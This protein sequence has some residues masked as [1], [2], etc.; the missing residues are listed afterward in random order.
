MLCP[1][2]V[3]WKPRMLWEFRNDCKTECSSVC[4]NTD[5]S[6]DSCFWFSSFLLHSTS[7]HSVPHSTS[8]ILWTASCYILTLVAFFIS[9]IVAFVG[10]EAAVR[11]L[12]GLQSTAELFQPR[13]LFS[14]Y[15]TFPKVCHDHLSNWYLHRYIYLLYLDLHNT[16]VKSKI[17]VFSSKS[18]KGSWQCLCSMHTYTLCT[19]AP[20][21]PQTKATDSPGISHQSGNSPDWKLQFQKRKKCCQKEPPPAKK[22]EHHQATKTGSLWGKCNCFICFEAGNTLTSGGKRTCKVLV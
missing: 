2:I 16:L 7:F 10:T 22:K 12:V 6:S 14:Y 1:I 18:V 20:G 15:L 4:T 17:L 21:G 13:I 3:V 9:L 8:L 19:K 11:D 5:R